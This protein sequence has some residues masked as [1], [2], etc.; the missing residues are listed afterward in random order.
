MIASVATMMQHHQMNSLRRLF[1][2]MRLETILN[3]RL[4]LGTEIL[5]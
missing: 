4:K 2:A 3:F 1:L 5:S